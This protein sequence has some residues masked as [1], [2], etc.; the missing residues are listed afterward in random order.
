MDYNPEDEDYPED[1]H[2]YEK[3]HTE[4]EDEY[5]MEQDRQPAEPPSPLRAL[6]GLLFLDWLFGGN[7]N[8]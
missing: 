7:D 6:F 3:S 8:C 4:E 1:D 5:R 2:K